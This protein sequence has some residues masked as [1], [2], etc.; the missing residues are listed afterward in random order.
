MNLL[1]DGATLLVSSDIAVLIACFIAAWFVLRQLLRIHQQSLSE[2]VQLILPPVVFFLGFLTLLLVA[3]LTHQQPIIFPRYGLI[4]F[5]LGLPIL[6]WTFLRVK[7]QKPAMA[8]R[9]LVG[10]VLILA[11]D[12]SIQFAGAVGT[13]NQY[14]VQR[15]AGEYLHDHF[16]PHSSSRIFCDEGSVRVFSGIPEERFVTSAD[17]PRDR[18][19][20]LSYLKANEVEYLVFV[21]HQ[22][23]TPNRVFNNL[24]Q[25][26]DGHLFERLFNSHTRFL[27]TEIW[28]YR[29][30]AENVK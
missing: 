12:A 22:P 5:T 28:V 29:L 24:E 10:I 30:H 8:R 23:T 9:L 2:E 4:L 25:G 14:Y 19:G 21:A 27:P 13:I 15:A 20:F 6:A 26:D 11:L 7:G 16:D 3:Y 1:R 18:E 17:V